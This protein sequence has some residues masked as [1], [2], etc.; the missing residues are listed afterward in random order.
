MMK[1]TARAI[2]FL[3]LAALFLF[4]LNSVL[5]FKYEDGIL[6]MK[7]FYKQKPDSV[8]VLVLGSSHSFTDIDPNIL[9]NEQGIAAYDLCA[10]M[11][12]TWHTYY[13]LKEALKYQKPKLIVMDVFRLVENFDY[14]KDSKLI[15]STYGMRPSKNKL[16]AIRAGLLEEEQDKA[17][18]YFFGFFLS[19]GR[20]QDLTWADFTAPFADYSN[21]KGFYPAYVTREMQ[22]PD[23]EGVTEETPITEKTWDYFAKTMELSKKEQIPVLLINVPYIMSKDDKAV[24]NT[25]EKKLAAFDESYQITY[26]DFNNLY[27]ELNI[28]FSTDFADSEHLNESGIHKLDPYLAQYI[29]SHY[30]LPDR[31]K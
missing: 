22:R 31:R 18:Q 20:Y 24:F 26:L 19:H 3:A 14:S 4:Y 9:Y 13:D 21:Y 8:D 5:S 28:D 12:S 1:K 7:Q 17:Y 16:D 30:A 6:Q 29:K 10:S 25:F 23:V 15:K 27:E 11:Q 2:C